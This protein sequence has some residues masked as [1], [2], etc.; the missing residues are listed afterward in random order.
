MVPDQPRA[1][2]PGEVDDDNAFVMGGIAGHAGVFATADAIARFGAALLRE[3]DSV[4]PLQLGEVLRELVA[5]DPA[6]EGAARGLRLRPSD[7]RAELHRRRA[8]GGP[9]RGVRSPRVHRLLALDRPGPRG[10]GGVV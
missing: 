2:S 10:V 1:Q 9:T 6:E 5:I 4:G 3:I 7:A 8:R